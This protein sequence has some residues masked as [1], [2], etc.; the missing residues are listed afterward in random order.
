M[1]TREVLVR[2]LICRGIMDDGS[3][4]Q[5]CYAKPWI[6]F[7]VFGWKILFFPT[8]GKWGALALHDVNHLLS[9]CD[10]SWKGE[11]EIAGWEL[12]S[13]GCGWHLLYWVDR[14]STFAFGL[15]LA[16]RSV[17]R[18][19][20]RGMGHRNAFRLSRRVVLEMEFDDLRRFASI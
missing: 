3:R 16:P 11:F 6:S 10:T 18:G 2:Y 19:L 17:L 15:V 8:W 5:D 20:Q 9:E 12:A 1:K 7:P 13:G 14:V 4:W